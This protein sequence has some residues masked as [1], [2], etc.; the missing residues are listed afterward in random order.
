MI[1]I[2]LKNYYITCPQSTKH[3][4]QVPLKLGQLYQNGLL[5]IFGGNVT[6]LERLE[7]TCHLQA[8]FFNSVF[9]FK[10]ILCALLVALL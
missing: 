1:K 2:I 3:S 6:E 4:T 9:L 10:D 8:L 5:E 7:K